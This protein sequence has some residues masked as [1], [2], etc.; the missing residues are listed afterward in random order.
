MQTNRGALARYFVAASLARGADSGAAIGLV[1]L[2]V[3]RPGVSSHPEAIGGILAAGLTAP[4]LLGPLLARRLDQTHDTRWYLFG[5]FVVYG[6]TLAAAALLLGHAPLA[7]VLLATLIAGACGPLLTGGMSS[8][9]AALCGPDQRSRR[10][11]EG[12]DSVSYGLAGTA[13]PAGVAA[14]TGATNA[15]TALLAL[16]GAAVLAAFLTLTLPADTRHGAARPEA[17]TVRTVL[18]LL[19]HDG[20]LRRVNFATMLTA[21]SGGGLAI[22]AVVVA[23]HLTGR[24][25]AGAALVALVGVGSLAG[26]LLL[27]AF[28]VRGE[29]ELLTTRYVS[30]V[31]LATG[32]CALAPNYPVALVS[33]T[34]IGL[35]NAPFVTATFAARSEYA[36]PGARAQVF[37]TMSSLKVAAASAGAAL[38]GVLTTL[39]P[40]GLPAAAASVVLLGALGMI[41][42]RRL[43]TG[44]GPDGQQ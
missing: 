41:V 13:G 11:G 30:L 39:G 1:L 14:L 17:A 3:S 2:A 25:T 42:D 9:V 28:P 31:G 32:L 40:R 19:L 4:H 33:F 29:P 5:A 38:A 22:I 26:S 23:T 44:E 18:L 8:R 36:P 12:W 20:P 34:L 43:T 16:S 24:S 15:L 37:V 27:T 10:R 35:A 6:G 21:F 7:L